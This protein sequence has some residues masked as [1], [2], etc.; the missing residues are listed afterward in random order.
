[1]NWEQFFSIGRRDHVGDS[2]KTLLDRKIR[3]VLESRR[4]CS[5]GHFSTSLKENGDGTDCTFSNRRWSVQ[6]CDGG[7]RATHE[8]K[9]EFKG[10]NVAAGKPKAAMR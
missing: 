10:V 2:F 7:V 5:N 9:G 8:H 4:R 6:Y 1:M 3:V